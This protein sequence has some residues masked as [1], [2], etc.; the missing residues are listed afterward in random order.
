[1][2]WDYGTF[3]PPYTHSS[4]AHAQPSS[5]ARCLN[6]GRTLCQLPYF[7]Y[8]NSEGSGETVWM[9]RFAWAFAGRLC[10]KYH[11]T[12]AGSYIIALEAWNLSSNFKYKSFL[13]NKHYWFLG[14]TVTLPYHVKIGRLFN[15]KGSL[16]N[17]VYFDI[18]SSFLADCENHFSANANLRIGDIKILFNNS[19]IFFYF[20]SIYF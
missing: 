10:D 2:S 15:V 1:M 6:F 19:L 5:G 8:A 13:K 3:H 18:H 20:F 17:A 12:W 14:K 9:R 4:N 11:I 7:M 16:F